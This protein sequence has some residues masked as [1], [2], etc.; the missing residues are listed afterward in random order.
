MQSTIT[1]ILQ[2]MNHKPFRDP[3]AKTPGWEIEREALALLGDEKSRA[4]LAIFHARRESQTCIFHVP[5]LTAGYY[6]FDSTQFNR[7]LRRL[8]GSFIEIV[9]AIRGAPRDIRLLPRWEHPEKVEELDPLF[10]L[11]KYYA[12]G[13]GYN[14]GN[15]PDEI[16]SQIHSMGAAHRFE[17]EP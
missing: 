5:L 17:A 14:E 15:N 3:N 4:I 8:E 6:G 9:E 16:T 12:L 10:L 1:Q 7:A 2:R 13:M 11:R